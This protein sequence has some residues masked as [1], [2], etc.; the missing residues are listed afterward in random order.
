MVRLKLMPPLTRLVG[1]REIA[2]EVGRVPLRSVLDEAAA[3]NARFRAA[4]LDAEG[5][6][7]GEYTCLVNGRRCNVSGL[8]GV[9]VDENDEIVL[10][11]PIAGGAPTC[12]NRL[13]LFAPLIAQVERGLFRRGCGAQ[14]RRERGGCL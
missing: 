1:A 7:S 5:N 12:R 3:R 9:E 13:A 4:I 10:L 14:K 11:M 6:L 8:D 2:V